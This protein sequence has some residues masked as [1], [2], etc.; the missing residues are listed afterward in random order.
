M[1]NTNTKSK[2]KKDEIKILNIS[3]IRKNHLKKIITQKA[4]KLSDQTLLENYKYRLN[5]RAFKQIPLPNVIIK[6]GRD[7]FSNVLLKQTSNFINLNKELNE[8]LNG[9]DVEGVN[10]KIIIKKIYIYIN[11]N[12]YNILKIVYKLYIL[13]LGLKWFDPDIQKII[14]DGKKINYNDL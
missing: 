10:A 8:Y 6:R 1:G 14:D 2:L 4:Y 7:I 9:Y 13:N 11:D 3:N 12:L 5:Q